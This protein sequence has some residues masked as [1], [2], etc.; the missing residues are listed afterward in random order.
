VRY[1]SFALTTAQIR[2][3]TKT[4]TR[5]LGWDFLRPGTLFWAVVKARGLKRGERV[6]RLALLRC[7][8][9][10]LVR[11][12]SIDQDDLVREGFPGMTPEEFIGMFCRMNRCDRDSI[13]NRIEFEYVEV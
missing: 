6:E 4:V 12:S 8:S 11:L 13:V 10:Q 9:N 5:R 3:R 1:M 2:N 7:V